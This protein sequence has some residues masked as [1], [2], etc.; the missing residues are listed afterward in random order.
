M[1]EQP[2]WFILMCLEANDSP[3]KHK[4]LTILGCSVT[5]AVGLAVVGIELD[6]VAVGCSVGATVVELVGAIVGLTVGSGMGNELD[7][8]LDVE[9]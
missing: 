7:G 6:G 9:L 3:F 4:A 1:I 8:R 2:A 5:L